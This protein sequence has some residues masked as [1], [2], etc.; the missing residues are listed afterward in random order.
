MKKLLMTCCLALPL[1]V[2]PT[3]AWAGSCSIGPW[4]VDAGISYHLNIMCNGQKLGCSHCPDCST[5]GPWYLYW[6]YEA[7]FQAQAPM[8]FPYWPSAQ[9]APS[10]PIRAVTTSAGVNPSYQTVAY[11]YY[12]RTTPNY[13]YGR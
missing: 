5:A 7:H 9:P 10:A 2:L 6:P 11:Y 13:W 12:P 4:S 8:P 3:K 1:M